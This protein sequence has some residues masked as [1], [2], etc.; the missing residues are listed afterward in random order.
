M[1]QVP[2]DHFVCGASI[3]ITFLAT[4]PAIRHNDP[5][6]PEICMTLYILYHPYMIH[7]YIY[8]VFIC[9]SCASWLSNS[10][11]FACNYRPPRFSPKRPPWGLYSRPCRHPG[12]SDRVN[13][14]MVPKIS[15]QN[16]AEENLLSNLKPNGCMK[17]GRNFWWNLM[18][19]TVSG[20]R[21]GDPWPS[22]ISW[23]GHPAEIVTWRGFAAF[24]RW[25]PFNQQQTE[26]SHRSA[27]QWFTGN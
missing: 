6:C 25:A 16:G 3:P 20:L 2:F 9:S 22:P 24:G 21:G 10:T 14:R 17:I 1:A 12:P 18:R 23:P 27:R 26:Q 15:L 19:L 11:M 5:T 4:L 7:I 13:S 8:I